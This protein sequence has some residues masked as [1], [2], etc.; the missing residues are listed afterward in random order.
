MSTLCVLL[1]GLLFPI[2]STISHDDLKFI[3]DVHKEFDFETEVVIVD[4]ISSVPRNARNNLLKN[5]SRQITLLEIVNV[6]EYIKDNKNYEH[7]ALFLFV[8]DTLPLLEAIKKESNSAFK[9]ATWFISPRN[10]SEEKNMIFSFDS[11]VHLVKKTKDKI[12]IFEVYNFKDR[13]VINPLGFWRRSTGLSITRESKWDR[14]SDMF[15]EKLKVLFNFETG[16]LTLEEGAEIDKRNIKSVPWVSMVPDIFQSMATSLNFTFELIRPRDLKWGAIDSNGEWNGIVKDLIDE[17]ADMSACPLSITEPRGKV[18]DFGIPFHSG[19]MGF[20]V[21]KQSSSFSFEIYSKP[22]TATTWA[23]LYFMILFI[24][25][26]FGL[27]TK[28]GGEKNYKEFTFEK[29]FI[30][31]YG[32]YCGFAAR[33]WSVTPVNISG[34]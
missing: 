20:F 7:T 12:N 1:L 17:E 6:E 2:I 21:S 33:R 15:G 32:A 22:F 3:S 26:V 25:F 28:L 9:S 31:A 18:I 16:Y 27:I 8:N 29:C 5:S 19:A 11:N 34:R 13:Q 14:R 10:M 24:T 30:Y 4:N 23:V